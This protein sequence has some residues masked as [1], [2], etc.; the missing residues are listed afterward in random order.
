MMTGHGGGWMG[1]RWGWKDLLLII[2]LALV[3]LF[4]VLTPAYVVRV[5][6]EDH[7]EIIAEIEAESQQRLEHA[8]SV[9]TF[10]ISCLLAIP[11]EERTDDVFRDCIEAGF[12]RAESEAPPTSIP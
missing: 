1:K 6:H 5:Q 3:V 7:D 4:A 10:T 9:N 8:I 12:E 11:E 2:G